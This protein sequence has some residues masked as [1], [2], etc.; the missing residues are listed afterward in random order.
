MLTNNLF[1][2]TILLRTILFFT[3]SIFLFFAGMILYGILLNLKEEPLKDIL[4]K[5]NIKEI[6]NYRFIADRRNF[7]FEFYSAD[8]LVKSYRAAFGRNDAQ[9]KKDFD[10][11]ATP[12]GEFKLCDFIDDHLYYKYYNINF[13][14]EDFIMEAYKNEDISEEEYKLMIKELKENNCIAEGSMPSGGFGIHG[15]GTFNFVFKNLPFVFNW[16]NGSIALSNEAIDELE[17]Y[18]KEGTKI[19]IKN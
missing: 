18:L 7:R 19:E 11:F 5:K 13:P 6:K 16:T 15:M 14:D 8:T 17:P 2:Q 10:D 3:G 4:K 9:H 1:S 12:S